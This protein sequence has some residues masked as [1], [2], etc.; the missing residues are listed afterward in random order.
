M[1]PTKVSFFAI[2][3]TDLC[4]NS[5][6]IELDSGNVNGYPYLLGSASINTAIRKSC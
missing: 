5:K 3:F 2:N 4:R 1:L 6:C